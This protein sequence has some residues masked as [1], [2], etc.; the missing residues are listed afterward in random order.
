VSSRRRNGVV[1]AFGL[2]ALFDGLL[3]LRGLEPSLRLARRLGATA[4]RDGWSDSDTETVAHGVALAAAFYPRRALCLEQSLALFVALRRDGAPA[5][6]RIGVRPI[7]FVAHAWVEIGGRPV[8]ELPDFIAQL[9][10]FPGLG[11]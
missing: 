8:N 3:R 4:A 10:P 5:V 7:P 11:G 6:L 9:A 2:L 1:R